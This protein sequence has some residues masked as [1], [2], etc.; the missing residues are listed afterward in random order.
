MKIL[1]ISL[2]GIGDTLFATPMI[3][4]I[5]RNFPNSE[6]D[7]LVM[8]GGAKQILENNPDINKVFQFNMIK[9]GYL[10]SLS[11]CLNLRKENYD[12]SINT[13]PQSKTQYRLVSFMIGAKRRLSHSYDKRSL[14][15]GLFINKLLKQDYSLHSADNNLNLLKFL[16]IERIDYSNPYKIYLNEENKKSANSF[17]KEN[18]LTKKTL[19]GISVG[20]G[21]TK[22]LALRR[23]PLSY[24]VSFIKETLK[25]KRDIF[26][27]LFGGPEEMN[28]NLRII[29]EVNDKRVILVKKEHILD[30]AAIISKCKFFLSVDNVL[31]HVAAATGVKNQI[32]I[33]T[34]TNQTT[35]PYKK[36][37]LLVGNSP[38]KSIFY[39]HDGEGIYG[40]K[41]DIINYMRGITPE[42]LIS[43]LNSLD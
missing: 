8:W 16:K 42:K 22:N 24:Y 40:R 11:F 6:I 15:D 33:N 21:K 28:D 31:M 39:K 14:F 1:V 13:H 5:R 29:N 4:E 43:A 12:L 36:S 2:A 23:W 27:L 9:E 17:I 18:N 35:Y 3:H 19:F 25:S 32:V 30:S 7:V 20:T 34:P 38:P 26:F 10:K 41:E 37:F